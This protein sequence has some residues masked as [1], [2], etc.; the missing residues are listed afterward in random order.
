MKKTLTATPT[1]QIIVQAIIQT[2]EV[3]KSLSNAMNSHENE[4]QIMKER[5]ELLESH[6]VKER[7]EL[8]EA[9]QKQFNQIETRFNDINFQQI[10][11]HKRLTRH[12]NSEKEGTQKHKT[13]ESMQTTRKPLEFYLP[14]AIRL[15][16]KYRDK[17]RE[18][19]HGVF[20]Q[21]LQ[22]R[23]IHH[24]TL[25]HYLFSQ[26]K[27][28]FEGIEIKFLHFYMALLDP[29][30]RIPYIAIILREAERLG[31]EVETTNT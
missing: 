26:L 23:N 16:A 13:T 4:L 5:Q 30:T 27:Q 21:I 6:F 18:V 7:Q 1:N 11:M 15:N 2:N 12:L 29:I 22:V 20:N 10:Q 19:I 24:M 31:I 17:T 14:A 9:Q 28:D 8:L 25:A 3:I